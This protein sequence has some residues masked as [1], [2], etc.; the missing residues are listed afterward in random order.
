MAVEAEARLESQRV[1]GAQA[2]RLD[3]ASASSSRANAST[4]LGGKRNL[5]AVLAG[6]AGA[7]DFR[8][9]PAEANRA[10]AHERH[11]VDPASG[12]EPRQH[13]GG[14][15][16][17]QGDERRLVA[18]RELDVLRQVGAQQ[19]EVDALARG[20]DDERDPPL[21]ARRARRHQI[22]DDAALGVEE[23][24][25]TLATGR[26]GQNVRRAERLE[27]AR[28]R[29]V[30]GAVEKGLTHMRN[31]EQARLRARVEMFGENAR[32][33]YWIGIS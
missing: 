30:I 8:F 4:S 29:L 26:E 16:P 5:E 14:G 33:G 23:L 24:R 11:R 32:L 1:A 25:V 10:H 21:G 6:V 22:V 15:R 18:D 13:R 20:V 12:R 28:G 31:I 9:E 2:D 17:L 19:R 27:R 7:R 3:L